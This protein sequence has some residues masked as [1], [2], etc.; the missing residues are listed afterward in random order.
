MKHVLEAVNSELKNLKDDLSWHKREYN[1]F[2][3]A[4]HKEKKRA[5]E[6]EVNLNAANA[7]IEELREK[8]NSK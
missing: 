8:L 4:F 2:R 7:I 5:D 3:D 1:V 6:L